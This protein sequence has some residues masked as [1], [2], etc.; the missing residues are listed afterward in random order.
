L[1]NKPFTIN[2]SSSDGIETFK[3]RGLAFRRSGHGGISSADLSRT[4]TA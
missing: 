1:V 2:P 3:D 4:T